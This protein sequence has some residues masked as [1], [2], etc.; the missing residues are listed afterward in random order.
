MHDLTEG[1]AR[2]DMALIISNLI[3]SKFFSLEVLNNRL[4]LFDYESLKLKIS[5]TNLINVCII[6]SAS[7]MLCLV[8]YFGLIIGDLVPR[9]N[10]FW[11]LYNLLIV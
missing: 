9:K 4:E 8:R 3:N 11:H 2:Y 1:V 7:E 6:M 10:K 5:S